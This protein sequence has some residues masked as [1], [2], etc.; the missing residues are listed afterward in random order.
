MVCWVCA[1]VSFW[2]AAALLGVY[3]VAVALRVLLRPRDG[4][5]GVPGAGIGHAAG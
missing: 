2:G 5:R 4:S 1:G 3:A